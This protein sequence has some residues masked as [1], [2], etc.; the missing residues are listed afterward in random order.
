MKIDLW[1]IGITELALCALRVLLFAEPIL[2]CGV[3]IEQNAGLRNENQ[4]LFNVLEKYNLNLRVVQ[5]NYQNVTRK[6]MQLKYFV[7]TICI[8][9]QLWLYQ[10]V[11]SEQ[12]I[13]KPYGI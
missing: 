9:I 6:S 8:Q 4:I 11:G 1:N 7:L 10:K 2:N 5:V 12:N 3:N 13:G